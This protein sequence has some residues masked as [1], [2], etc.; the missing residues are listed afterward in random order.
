LIE[1][2]LLYALDP[3]SKENYMKAETPSRSILLMEF[4]NTVFESFNLWSWF[5]LMLGK[6]GKMIGEEKTAD[7]K[8]V[9]NIINDSDSPFALSLL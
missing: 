2:I 1:T 4:A 3:Y 9:R 5:L 6:S 8:R 7:K